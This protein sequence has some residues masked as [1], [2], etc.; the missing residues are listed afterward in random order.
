[1]T[2]QSIR[3]GVVGV[4]YLGAIHARIYAAMPGVELMGVTDIDAY[5]ATRVAEE[6]GCSAYNEPEALL[7]KVDAVSI[8][9]PTSSHRVVAE[10]YLRHG[11]HVLL[12]K[13]IADHL[14]N[15]RAIVKAAEETGVIL[16]IG[17]LERFN[18]GVVRLV[19]ELDRPRFIEVHRLGPFVSRAAD[20]DV[21]TDLMIHDIDIVLSLVTAELTYVSAVGAR[22]VSAHVDIANA[23]LEF[24]D[25][26]I[27]NVTASRVSSRKFRRIRVFGE[28]CYLGL[29]FVNQQVEV[30]RRTPPIEESGFAGIETE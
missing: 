30:S 18:A 23:R 3:V 28:A 20:V 19:Q 1:M 9:V 26:T 4:G 5:V 15:A 7:D 25:G 24:A 22:V 13:P 27:A 14:T 8:V 12:E 29:D 16:Q 17:H 6:C 10:P 11:M 2:T 21:V